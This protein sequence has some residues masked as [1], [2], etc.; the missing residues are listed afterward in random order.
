MDR[1]ELEKSVIK[2]ICDE[3]ALTPDKVSV[4]SRLYDDLGMD[5]LEASSLVLSIEVQF[6]I[7]MDVELYSNSTVGTVVDG[8]AEKLKVIN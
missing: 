1:L 2:I 6:N 8:L 7:E 4:S 5:S 3:M